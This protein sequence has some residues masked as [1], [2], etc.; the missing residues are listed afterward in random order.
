MVGGRYRVLIASVPWLTTG[1]IQS[2]LRS[3]KMH[4]KSQPFWFAVDRFTYIR[5]LNSFNNGNVDNL[6]LFRYPRR[7]CL[8]L[9]GLLFSMR[10]LLALKPLVS[11]GC[12]P[13]G[14]FAEGQTCALLAILWIVPHLVLIALGYIGMQ[15]HVRYVLFCLV[16]YYVLVAKGITTIPIPA[17]RA[18]WVIGIILYSGFAL[19][20]DYFRAYKENYRGALLHVASAQQPG[21]CMVNFPNPNTD[22]PEREWTVYLSSR[23]PPRII[24]PDTIESTAGDC[25]RV[26]FVSWQVFPAD[27]D[28]LQQI[29][30]KLPAFFSKAEER[31]YLWVGTTLFARQ[32]HPLAF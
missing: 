25:G 24:P 7:S 3:P 11:R 27:A 29:E 28:Q 5:D 32:S 16:P 4:F 17:A 20:A 13:T 19:R 31:H 23:T 26:W 6:I 15:Y 14:R 1:I 30:R 10:A 21:D 12:A 8:A 2:A 18:A 22:L 9:G